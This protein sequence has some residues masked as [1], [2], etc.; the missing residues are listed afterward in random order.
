MKNIGELIVRPSLSH[1]EGHEGH[2]ERIRVFRGKPMALPACLPD[3]G[4]KGAYQPQ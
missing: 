2:E 1:H 4:L 3:D